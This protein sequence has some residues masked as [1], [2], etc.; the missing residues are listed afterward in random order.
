MDYQ[1]QTGDMF[2]EVA[3]RFYSATDDPA[4]VYGMASAIKADNGIDIE[5]SGNE[6]IPGAYYHLRDDWL[7]PSMRAN[8]GAITGLWNMTPMNLMLIGG[9]GLILIAVLGDKK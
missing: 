6:M 5:N 9:V 2:T 1:A 7:R 8:G 3:K 4:M